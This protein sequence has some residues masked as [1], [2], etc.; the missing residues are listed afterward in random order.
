MY[1]GRYVKY[2]L[3]LS[4]LNAS[5]TSRQIFEKKNAPISNLMKIPQVGAEVFHTDTHDLAVGRLPQFCER[6]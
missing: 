6:A 5:L 3:F 1:V 2:L 4:D